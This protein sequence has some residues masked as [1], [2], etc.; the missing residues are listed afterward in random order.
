[1]QS[2]NRYLDYLIDPSFRR[3]N[4]LFVLTFDVNANRL[5][6]L[7]YYLPTMNIKDYNVM[8]DGKT[9]LI[10]Q[11]KMTTGQGDDYTSS[12]LLDYNNFN[13]HYQMRAIDL[14]KQQAI[15]VDPKAIQQISFTRNLGGANN[16]VIFFIIEVAKET[17]LD[18]SQGTGKVL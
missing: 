16:R 1:M 11:L 12:C 6:H 7:R 9:F 15:D 18:S 3:V 14:S 8:I 4:R 10:N 17:I 13:K 2:P 5:G